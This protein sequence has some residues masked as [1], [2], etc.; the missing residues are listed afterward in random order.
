MGHFLNDLCASMW[1]IYLNYYLIYVV[2]LSQ[3]VAAAALLS[4]QI[5]D[6]I[7]TP[8]VGFSSDQF[9]CKPGKRNTWYYFGT[10][11]TIPSFMCIF[12][13]TPAFLG[14]GQARNLWYIVWPA[15]FNVGWAC[16]QISHMSI[17]NQLSYS[18]RRRDRM[19]NNRNGA[20]YVA[21]IAVLSVALVLF[22]TIPLPTT[23]FTLLCLL[24][25]VTG[26]CTSLFYV[27]KIKENYLSE[28]AKI[29]EAE[30]Q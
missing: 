13:K 18:V 7:T 5:T 28:E 24:C 29:L 15:I 1:F 20:T 19:V 3:G 16:V 2:G 9:N 10:L 17:V 8:I 26:S 21:N 4:G 6:G 25:I 22:I 11:L 30:Y 12:V 23:S 14:V 27:A